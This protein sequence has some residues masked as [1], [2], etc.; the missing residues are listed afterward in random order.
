M[1]RVRP[2]SISISL[3][4]S[5][6]IWKIHKLCEQVEP[7]PE[8]DLCIAAAAVEH[9]LVPLTENGKPPPLGRRCV[10]EVVR[11]L[12]LSTWLELGSKENSTAWIQAQGS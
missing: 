8:D 9:G 5:R 12:V 1:S 4:P 6:R 10:L 3:A 2:F 11:K 7:I